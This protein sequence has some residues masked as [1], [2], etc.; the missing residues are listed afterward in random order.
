ME[1]QVRQ[2]THT[3]GGRGGWLSHVCPDSRGK[4]EASPQTITLR[5]RGMFPALTGVVQWIECQP[6]NQR[7]T[8]SIPNQGTCLD[9]G[10]GPQ[11]VA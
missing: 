6:A 3:R 5:S 10:P 7:A 11:L 4:T 9:C 2:V 8:D 1:V